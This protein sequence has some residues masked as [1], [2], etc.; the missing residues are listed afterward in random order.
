M[1][2]R[3]KEEK[4]RK[5]E[6]ERTQVRENARCAGGRRVGGRGW[7]VKRERRERSVD[8]WPPEPPPAA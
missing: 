4:V 5:K 8:D 3:E 2:I 7:M 6:K 1:E